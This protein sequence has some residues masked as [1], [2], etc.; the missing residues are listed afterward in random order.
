MAVTLQDVARAAQVSPATVSRVLNDYPHV[1]EATREAVLQAVQKLDYPLGKLRRTTAIFPPGV[2]LVSRLPD[3]QSEQGAGILH[4][5]RRL[6]TGAQGVLERRGI[7]ARVQSV[8][9]E[10]SS[11]QQIA[12][13]PQVAGLILLGGIVDYAF[14]DELQAL[15]LPTVVAGA[16][17]PSPKVN[18]VTADYLQGAFQA[19]NHLLDQGRRRLGLVNGPPTTMSSA[20]KAQGFRLAL[21]MHDLPFDPHS[22]AVS[23]EFATE[24]GYWQTLHLLSQHPDLDAIVYAGDSMAMGGLRAIKETER[25]VP[26]DVAISGFYDTD[27]ARFTDPPLTSVHVDMNAIGQAAAHR[28]C[29]LIAR[30]CDQAWCILMPASLIVRRST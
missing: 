1:S 13:D 18:C 24:P 17:T 5:D 12:E 14:A 19:A 29:D 9:M 25:Q 27:I 26:E 7:P 10:I 20:E 8:S 30:P 11:A 21:C 2:L 22:V 23:E 15:E 3:W 16:R 4:I 28:L 6:I